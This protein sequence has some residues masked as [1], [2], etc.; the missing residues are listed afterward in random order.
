[1]HSQYSTTK[2]PPANQRALRRG[3]EIVLIAILHV[4]GKHA[5]TLRRH[6]SAKPSSA[7]EH[8]QE[9]PQPQRARNP[10]GRSDP[11]SAAG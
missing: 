5:K 9:D 8:L 7:C 3:G 10:R 2:N 4:P 1:M 11:E 6:R